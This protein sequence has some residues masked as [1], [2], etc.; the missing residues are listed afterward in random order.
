MLSEK[1]IREE[2][3]HLKKN[4]GDEVNPTTWMQLGM[5]DALEM[6]LETEEWKNIQDTLKFKIECQKVG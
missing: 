2:L 3:D 1:E 4:I 5:I 6:V